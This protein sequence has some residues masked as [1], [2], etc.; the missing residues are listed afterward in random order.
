VFMPPDERMDET[1]ERLRSIGM[2][3]LHG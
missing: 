1:F 2:R 3:E